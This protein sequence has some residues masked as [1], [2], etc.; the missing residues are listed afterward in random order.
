MRAPGGYTPDLID[1]GSS[2]SVYDIYADVIA[3]DEVRVDLHK[4]KYYGVASHQKDTLSYR[5]NEQEIRAKFGD[6]VK[7]SGRYPSHIATVMC[8]FFI[9]ATFETYE[10]AQEFDRFVRA[11]R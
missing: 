9:F 8:D 11:K 2:V 3:Y 6:H 5:H 10:E 1:Y 7:M 4:K